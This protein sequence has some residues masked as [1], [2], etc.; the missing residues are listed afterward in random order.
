MPPGV[1]EGII[2]AEPELQ[3]V[4]RLV[5]KG[6][7]MSKHKRSRLNQRRR[8]VRTG[9]WL[10]GI[11]VLALTD[12]WWPGIL[13]LIG[14]SILVSA[15]IPAAAPAGGQTSSP[16]IPVEAVKPVMPAPQSEPAKAVAGEPA[17]PELP[18]GGWLPDTCPYCGGPIDRQKVEWVDRRRASCPYCGSGIRA[19]A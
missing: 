2:I 15:W 17:E 1:S 4:I 16:V 10:I 9:I 7:K 18:E 14:L 6:K 13:F 8:A 12:W 11:G 19:D 5:K 3:Q